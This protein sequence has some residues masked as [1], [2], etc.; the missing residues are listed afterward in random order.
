MNEMVT[1]SGNSEWSGDEDVGNDDMYIESNHSL[2]SEMSYNNS[3]L[4]EHLA[5]M[6]YNMS[7]ER[8]ISAA[9]SSA[10][11]RGIYPK[12]SRTIVWKVY[13]YFKERNKRGNLIDTVVQATGVSR[14]TVVRIVRE[15]KLIETG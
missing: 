9:A 14:A 3:D 11:K 6:I 2:E 13:S 10:T 15:G 7:D 5:S 1:N 4:D 8:E 12:E